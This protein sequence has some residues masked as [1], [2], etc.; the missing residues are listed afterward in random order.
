M[1]L[2]ITSYAEPPAD[3][4][5]LARECGTFY[6]DARWIAGIA[7]TFGYR[8]HCL[9][10][11][12]G[13]TTVGAL[14]LA[15]VPTPW[16]G[17]RLVSF[18][19]SFI[20]GPMADDPS[21]A[22]ALCERALEVAEQ[23]RARRLEIKQYRAPPS[24]PGF[25]RSQRYTT[26]RIDTTGGKEAVWSR[27]HQTSVRQRIRKGERAG[28]V[29][30]VG[31]GPDEWLA[32]ARLVERV[33]QGHGVPAPPRRFFLELCVGLQGAGLVDLYLARV[34]DGRVA[35]GFVMY[36]GPREWVYALSAADPSLVREFRPPHVLLWDGIK[37]AIAA[38]VSVD[39]GRSAPEQASLADF[40]QRWGA[41]A[42]PLAYDYWPDAGGLGE[43]RRDKGVAALGAWMWRRLPAP[44]AR[45]GSGLYRYLG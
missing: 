31:G 24:V 21:V 13:E 36:R 11:R 20:A 19:F 23:V 6:H 17:R 37:R 33:Q 8:L 1:P 9:V 45:L 34:P 32:L 29:V 10:A 26:Y 39:L 30:E 35:G 2:T 25:Q 40:K 43:A 28:V 38:G 16:G 15:E 5:A 42:V 22:G 12:N 27:F 4:N 7:D 18:P 3:W 41:E 44:V 14:A